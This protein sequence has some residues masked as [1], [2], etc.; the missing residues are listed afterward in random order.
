MQK[1]V[2]YQPTL[3]APADETRSL[4]TR[5][6][7]A[8]AGRVRR[9]WGGGCGTA[10]WGHRGRALGIHPCH[11]WLDKS[12][13]LRPLPSDLDGA[14]RHCG[15]RDREEGQRGGREACGAN[16]GLCGPELCWPPWSEAADRR[17]AASLLSR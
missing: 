4:Q 16:S 13:A 7:E 5:E 9:V 11:P 12:P 17:Q 2:R 3:P 6:T 15:G 1:N 14:V 8:A 10:S